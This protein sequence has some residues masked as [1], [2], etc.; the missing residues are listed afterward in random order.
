[1]GSTELNTK[2]LRVGKWC[3]FFLVA[4]SFLLAIGGVGVRRCEG[5]EIPFGAKYR[6]GASDCYSVFPIDLD[7]DGDMDVVSALRVVVGLAPTA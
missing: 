4:S 6:I 3:S 5:G 7:R 1:M 2:A